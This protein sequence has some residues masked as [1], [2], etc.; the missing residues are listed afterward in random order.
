MKVIVRYHESVKGGDGALRTYDATVEKEVSEDG[1]Q[2][3]Q[4]AQKMRA[5]LHYLH[6]EIHKAIKKE[7]VLDGI[8]AE[9]QS[10]HP[11]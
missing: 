5:M 8:L 2:P 3:E 7:Q 9:D 4:Q 1:L 11:A 6:V 10:A